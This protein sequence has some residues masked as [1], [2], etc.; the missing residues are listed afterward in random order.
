MAAGSPRWKKL[1]FVPLLLAGVAAL[2]FMVLRKEPPPRLADAERVTPARVVPAQALALVPRVKGYGKVEPVLAWS[3]LAEVDG[4]V[5]ATNPELERGALLRKDELLFR[6]DPLEYG[7]AAARDEAEVDNLLAQLEALEQRQRNLE[8]QLEVERRALDLAQRE[9]E[10]LREL[11]DR[12]AVSSAE[13]DAEEQ[14]YL[15]QKNMVQDLEN[16]L[17]LIPTERRQLMASL[18]SGERRLEETQLDIDKTVIRAPFD[19]RVSEVNAEM[20]QYVAPGQTLMRGYAIHAVEVPAQTPIADMWRFMAASAQKDFPAATLDMASV[21][22]ALSLDAVVRLPVTQGKRITWPARFQRVGEAIDPTTRTLTL[23]VR[24]DDPYAGVGPGKR[25]PLVQN[26]YCE[27]EL[28]GTPLEERV[29]IP[30][31]ALREGVVHVVGPE[32]RLERRTVETGYL[33]ATIAAVDA[34]LR[35]G[36]RVVVSDL[37]PVIEGML[38]EPI[39]DNDLTETVRTEALA[40]DVPRPPQSEAMGEAAATAN[41]T[42]QRNPIEDPP[43]SSHGSRGGSSFEPESTP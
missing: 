31:A 12:G 13:V 35:A 18:E 14:R 9:W 10:R 39:A 2:A 42:P 27:V 6:I 17:E 11:L 16:S 20:S 41:A 36:E 21:R 29:V 24:V 33:G 5:V 38:L 15:A 37:V 32:N 28:F 19:L 4:R 23:Y 26:M 43:A 40:L 7:L 1:L 22:Q 25:P 34:G 3:A 30:R 8:R